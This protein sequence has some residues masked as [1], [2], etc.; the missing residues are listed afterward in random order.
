MG[1]RRTFTAE[2]KAEIVK[3]VT[4]SGKSARTIVCD[5]GLTPSAVDSWVKQA[6]VDGKQGPAGALT[7]QERLEFARLRK[8]N[9]D[10]RMER[11]FSKKSRSSL[12]R[13]AR[14]VCRNCRRE[15]RIPGFLDVQKAR[16][17]NQRLLRVGV[18]A[19]LGA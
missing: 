15:G 18:S 1:K 14:K 9:K 5:L 10:L 17:F 8:E 13:R 19:A 2:Y 16:C 3:M 6:N 4:D 12:R 11:K 7:T